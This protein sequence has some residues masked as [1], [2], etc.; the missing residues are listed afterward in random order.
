MTILTELPSFLMSDKINF[1]YK[2]NIIK[3]NSN[4]III[5][6]CNFRY[7]NIKDNINLPGFNPKITFS[8]CGKINKI[9]IELGH[10]KYDEDC[11][12]VI[13]NYLLQEDKI[14][15]FH[16]IKNIIEPITGKTITLISFCITSII[17][18]TIKRLIKLK[19]LKK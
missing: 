18:D 5:D 10:C 6:N 11:K 9:V 16:E 3:T 4:K 8:S 1:D 7:L 12:N 17:S 14:M 15:Y 13:I 2:S 19:L